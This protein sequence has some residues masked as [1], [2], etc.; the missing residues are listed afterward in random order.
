MRSDRVIAL[1]LSAV[2]LCAAAPLLAKAKKFSHRPHVRAGLECKACHAGVELE[3]GLSVKR[4]EVDCSSCHEAGQVR[5]PKGDWEPT[6]ALNFS[7]GEHIGR[8]GGDCSACHEAIS[9]EK[10]PGHKE[11]LACHQADYDAVNCR[12]CHSDLGSRNLVPRGDYSHAAGWMARH[13][14]T[15]SKDRKVCAQCHEESFCSDC[16]NIRDGMTPPQKYPQD[17]EARTIHR[18]D[19]RSRHPIEARTDSASCLKCHDTA[20]C[21]DCHRRE[22][23]DTGAASYPHPAGW[24]AAG[25]ANFHGRAARADVALCATCHEKGAATN[26]IVCHSSGSG[27]NPHPPGWTSSLPRS[28]TV[29]RRCH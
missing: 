3:T 27:N 2:L 6:S 11:C 28:A 12:M 1:A 4:I 25:S 20:S 29:C 15:A 21:M 22:G 8:V 18:A 17:V 14:A 13:K 10:L 26:C 23:V 16:H 7:H 24:M 19:F 5:P 9:K